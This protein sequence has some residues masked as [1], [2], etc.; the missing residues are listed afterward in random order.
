MTRISNIRAYE[1]LDSRGTPTVEAVVVLETGHEGR[2]SVPSG[3][4]TGKH[5]ALEL[6][7]AAEQRYGGLGVSSAVKNVL[8]PIKEALI[9]QDVSRQRE[10]DHFLRE[11]DGT[12][13]KSRLGAN[14]ILAVSIACAKAAASAKRIELHQ[15]I[16]GVN[17]NVLP[18][19][20]FNVLNGGRHADSGLDVQEYMLAPFGSRRRARPFAGE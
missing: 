12:P 11:L 19:P 14:A 5:E 20:L 4:S 6:R 10:L 15:Y 1:V 9:G 2:F 3:A 17:A 8:G 7:D 16:G 18:V 13:N